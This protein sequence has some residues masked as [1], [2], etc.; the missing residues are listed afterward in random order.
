MQPRAATNL[1]LDWMTK[2]MKTTVKMLPKSTE[3]T[4]LQTFAQ[5]K[6]AT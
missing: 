6:L 2:K 5:Q 1:K 3:E 4:C